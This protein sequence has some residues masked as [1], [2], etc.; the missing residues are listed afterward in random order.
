ME[1]NIGN[2]LTEAA[3]RLGRTTQRGSSTGWLIFACSTSR[4]SN[5]GDTSKATLRSMSMDVLTLYY[6]NNHFF[7]SC[8][9]SNILTL[10]PRLVATISVNR[11]SLNLSSYK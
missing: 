6:S 3:Q 9:L 10:Y 1:E 2:L 5:S 4:P 11:L 8:S 7:A